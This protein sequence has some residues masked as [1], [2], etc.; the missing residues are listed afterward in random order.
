MNKLIYT[1]VILAFVSSVNGQWSLQTNPLGTGIGLGKIQFVSSTEGWISGGQGNLLHTTNAGVNWVIVKP[2][3]NDTVMSMSDPSITMWWVGQA[4][5]WK[6]NWLGTGFNDARGAVMH[7]TTNGGSTWQKKVLSTEANDMGIQIQFAD[8]NTGWAAIYNISTLQGKIMKSTDGGN[9][10]S[11][12]PLSASDVGMFYFTDVS[13]GWSIVNTNSAPPYKIT[14]TTN[15]GLNWSVQYTD[16]TQGGFSAIQFT[17]LNNGWIV[18]RN[19]KILKTNNGGTNWIQINNTGLSD[20]MYSKC[21]FFINANTGWIGASY[22]VPPPQQ[23][24]LRV[25]LR[26]SN[27]GNSWSQQ[28]PSILNWDNAVFSIYFNDAYNGWF[29]A[30][31]GV[32]AHSTNGGSIGIQNISTE[33]PSAYSL[34]QNYPNP[35]NPTSVIRFS[36]SVACN[37]SLRIYDI[38]G[39]EVQT[40]VNERLQ[41]GTYETTFDGS[42]LSS[43]VYFYR[44]QTIGFTETKR[45]NF[46]K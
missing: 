15:G 17:D 40:L 19:R 2:F 26:T 36:L 8:A 28:I 25:I 27:G 6:M 33:I 16:N 18:G 29:T 7:F 3:P 30:E 31:N 43:G 42:N 39:R 32:I 10:W 5:G 23:T 14:H 44:L 9:N 35:F 12:I 13:N 45:M 11:I 41:A 34:S 1:L 46:I 22:Y 21:V 4:R 37:A 20:S 38:M 24:P